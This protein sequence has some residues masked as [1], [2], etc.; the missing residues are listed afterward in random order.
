MSVKFRD[1]YEIL[2][3]SRGISPDEIQKAYRKLARQY[4]PDRHQKK[5]PQERKK[6]EEKFKEIGEAYEVLKDPK[7]R[8]RYDALGANWKGGQDFS[9][10]PGF[11]QFFGRR[12]GRTYS[13]VQFDGVDGLSDFFQML[14]GNQRG[15]PFSGFQQNPCQEGRSHAHDS[16][17]GF[18]PGDFQQKGADHQADITISLENAFF[19]GKKSITLHTQEGGIFGIPKK[20]D[21]KYQIK[22]PA[23]VTN[24]T[25]IRLA[26][27]GEK[28]RGQKA[29]DLLLKI[30]IAPHSRFQI[31]GQNLLTT[32]KI[33]P[34]EAALG[35][36]VPVKTMDKE[37]KLTIPQGS[38]SGQILRIRGKGFP[39][40]NSKERGD[41]LAEL[42]IVVP[43]NPSPKELHLFEKLKETSN[44]DPRN[45]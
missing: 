12:H 5:S 2:G 32:V 37:I 44:F 20:K 13:N 10:P 21:R 40:K 16:S 8:E 11:E 35:T 4:H 36:K 38:Q 15:H 26:G 33:S 22:I 45:S 19:G 25:V 17:S 14:F 7:K 42:K 31:S 24:G 27:Q 3:I 41:L 23:G 29:G 18:S 39:K 28:G 6:S 43:K 34:W 1:Y 30:N 9:P